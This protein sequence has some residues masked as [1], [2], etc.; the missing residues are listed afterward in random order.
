[1]NYIKK[2][3]KF[4]TIFPGDWEPTYLIFILKNHGIHSLFRI[5]KWDIS[6]HNLIFKISH[7]KALICY[8]TNKMSLGKL[9]MVDIL[10]VR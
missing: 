1:M 8:V 5:P 4:I 7:E 6:I 10:M 3:T 9:L 2:I